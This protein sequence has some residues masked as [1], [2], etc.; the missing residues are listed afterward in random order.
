MTTTTFFVAYRGYYIDGTKFLNLIG[1]GSDNDKSFRILETDLNGQGITL[2]NVLTA[3]I[4]SKKSLDAF[5]LKSHNFNVKIDGNFALV[6]GIE[7][8]LVRNRDEDLVFETES[9]GTVRAIDQTLAIGKY[10]ITVRATNH[11]EESKFKNLQYCATVLKKIEPAPPMCSSSTSSTTVGKGFQSRQQPENKIKTMNAFIYRVIKKNH[12]TIYFLWICERYEQA[13]FF[14]KT[15]NLTVG[16]F[17]EGMFEERK[18]AKSNWQCFK[19]VRQIEDM[20][21]VDV[22]GN[23]LEIKTTISHYQPMT[24]MTQYPQVFAVHFGFIL[25]IKQIL[26]NLKTDCTGKTV[27]TQRQ[28]VGQKF[29]WTIKEVL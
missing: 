27:I 25:D 8:E 4:R 24:N 23:L 19:Y 15:Y 28:K 26:R 14:S 10:M 5:Q 9:F 29:A 20:F 22:V 7:G 16:H 1:L 6:D 18:N 2:G 12:R 3:V 11:K 17:F 21:P 13:I